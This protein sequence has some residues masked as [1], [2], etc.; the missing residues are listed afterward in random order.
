MYLLFNA[1][2]VFSKFNIVDAL[3]NIVLNIKPSTVKHHIKSLISNCPLDATSKLLPILFSKLDELPTFEITNPHQVIAICDYYISKSE[4]LN[5]SDTM[6]PENLDALCAQIKANHRKTINS[7]ES[8]ELNSDNISPIIT[9]LPSLDGFSDDFI[10]HLITKLNETPGIEPKVISKFSSQLQKPH[11]IHFLDISPP[12]L[13][14]SILSKLYL[15]KEEFD[16]FESYILKAINSS[17]LSSYRSLCTLP[18]TKYYTQRVLQCLY[19]HFTTHMTSPLTLSELCTII[20]CMNQLL[21]TCK[22]EASSQ[23]LIVIELIRKLSSLFLRCVLTETPT[24]KQL[25]LL[26]KLFLS[27]SKFPSPDNFQYLIACFVS[28]LSINQIDDDF[29]QMKRRTLQSSIFPLIARCSK[30]QIGEISTA[31]HESH[32]QVFQNLYTRF[33]SEAQYKG[34]V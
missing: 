8:I 29:E 26:T 19:M 28:H 18:I 24:Y 9:S 1:S 25:R 33:T 4:E 34:K 13:Y 32:R 7:L 6:F 20:Y 27:L 16:G 23:L 10:T 30:D 12:S 31:L 11:L 15:T 2:E 5:F 21:I 22:K 3:C 17:P 14:P